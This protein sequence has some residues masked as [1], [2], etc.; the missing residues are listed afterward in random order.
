MENP[1]L[2]I[3]VVLFPPSKGFRDI[4][5]YRHQG[6]A[7]RTG[8]GVTFLSRW[9]APLEQQYKSNLASLLLFFLTSFICFNVA[10]QRDLPPRGSQKVPVLGANLR[11]CR[12]NPPNTD[13][14]LLLQS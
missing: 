2:A 7:V 14:D 5:G 1:C 11:C 8:A 12:H 10:L 9:D 13:G 6:T 4:P 3:Y